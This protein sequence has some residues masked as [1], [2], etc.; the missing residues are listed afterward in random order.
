[1]VEMV[2][3]IEKVKMAKMVNVVN[4]VN[5]GPAPH[6]APCSLSRR[7]ELVKYDCS[8]QLVNQGGQ[9]WLILWMVGSQQP[10][11]VEMA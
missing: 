1:M 10:E 6:H 4:V 5:V 3:M 8:I 7:L 2:E 9:I 11:T